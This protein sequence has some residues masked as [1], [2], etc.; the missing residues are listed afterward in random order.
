MSLLSSPFPSYF[1]KCSSLFC[2]S[3]SLP[4]LSSSFSPSFFLCSRLL[5]LSLRAS[6]SARR[7]RANAPWH[8]LQLRV[9]MQPGFAQWPHSDLPQHRCA[10]ALCCGRG[11]LGW[12]WRSNN[13]EIRKEKAGNP[14]DAHLE[15]IS[16]PHV[17]EHNKWIWDHII[18][19][20]YM[21][22]LYNRKLIFSPCQ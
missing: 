10:E 6:C 18:L 3:I 19:F 2:L 21:I 1:L 13:S 11:Y 8:I 5:S 22:T 15:D 7:Q 20:M 14:W 4:S 16:V 9:T 17:N 12:G